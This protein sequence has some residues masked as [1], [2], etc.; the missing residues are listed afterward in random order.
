MFSKNIK[1]LSE[2]LEELQKLLND[3]DYSMNTFIYDLDKE[4][5]IEREKVFKIIRDKI[6]ELRKMEGEVFITTDENGNKI[7][8]IRF[9][10]ETIEVLQEI[11]DHIEMSN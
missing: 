9:Y 11:K 4:N 3:I 5:W 10:T 2:D 7:E 8:N 1:N 6:R